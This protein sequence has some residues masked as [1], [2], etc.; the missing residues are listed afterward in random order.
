MTIQLRFWSTF[1]S[2]SPPA[3]QKH[4]KSSFSNRGQRQGGNEHHKRDQRN[5]V[6]PL[7]REGE[8]DPE[9]QNLYL[10]FPQIPVERHFFNAP[11][12]PLTGPQDPLTAPHDPLIAPPPPPS[13]AMASRRQIDAWWLVRYKICYKRLDTSAEPKTYIVCKMQHAFI[14]VFYTCTGLCRNSFVEIRIWQNSGVSKH[15][16]NI[17]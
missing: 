7:L 4:F 11:Q 14:Q 10:P 2:T 17:K 3:A 8:E 1:C 5:L 12:D 13:S 16:K 9:E 6:F 15:V